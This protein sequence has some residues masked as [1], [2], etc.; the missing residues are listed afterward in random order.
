MT[1]R[2]MTLD[3]YCYCGQAPDDSEAEDTGEVYSSHKAALAGALDV[4]REVFRAERAETVS[5]SQKA[6]SALWREARE[7]LKEVGEV[8]LALPA[9]EDD[10]EEI[11]EVGMRYVAV[12]IEREES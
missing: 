11:S 1:Y 4:L 6:L 8:T 5:A 7:G 9:R 2:V 10:G 3:S 12:R